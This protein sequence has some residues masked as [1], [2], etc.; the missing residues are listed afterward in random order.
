MSDTPNKRLDNIIRPRMGRVIPFPRSAGQTAPPAS[1]SS[2]IGWKMLG[3]LGLGLIAWE[4]WK[5]IMGESGEYGYITRPDRS[6]IA[7]RR[8]VR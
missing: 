8:K 4:S 6:R 3:V 5:Y 2:G 1:D 7:R